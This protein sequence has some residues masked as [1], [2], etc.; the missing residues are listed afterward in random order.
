MSSRDILKCVYGLN[1]GKK[2]FLSLRDKDGN[3]VLHLIAKLP[4]CRHNNLYPAW[5]V[6]SVHACWYQ[7]AKNLY[8]KTPDQVFLREHHKMTKEANE[9]AKETARSYIVAALIVTIMLAVLFKGLG[10]KNQHSDISKLLHK[11][12]LS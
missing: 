7:G 6:K 11:K 10:G 4:D 5:E 2:A 12:L 1:V 8:G 3:N 9:W